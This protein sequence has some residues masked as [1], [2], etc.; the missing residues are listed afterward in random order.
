MKTSLR[1]S[2]TAIL[3]TLSVS[4]V[5]AQ[6]NYTLNPLTSFGGNGDGSIRPGQSIGVLTLDADFNQRG[7]ACDPLTTNLV[8]VDTHSGSAGS[9]NVLGNIYVVDGAAG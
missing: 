5:N 2:L 1:T 8:L 6:N 7:L 9:T 4:L 3:L